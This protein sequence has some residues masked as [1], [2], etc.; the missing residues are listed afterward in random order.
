L[1]VLVWGQV[2]LVFEGPL[3]TAVT[4]ALVFEDVHVFYNW[5]RLHSS[6]GYG[7]PKQFEAIGI[8]ASLEVRENGLSPPHPAPTMAPCRTEM[9]TSLALK[10]PCETTYLETAPTYTKLPDGRPERTR[11]PIMPSRQQ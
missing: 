11:N 1:K 2:K 10:R 9:H 5:V 3:T 7:S 8:E 6:L 4:R